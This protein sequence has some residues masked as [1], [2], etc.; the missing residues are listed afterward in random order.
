[1][2][3]TDIDASRDATRSAIVAMLT[4]RLHATRW[5]PR[6]ALVPQL[7]QPQGQLASWLA[8]QVPVTSVTTSL[9]LSRLVDVPLL[10]RAI[11]ATF[12][13]LTSSFFRLEEVTRCVRG[14][15]TRSS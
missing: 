3:R 12:D 1:M 5:M 13:L 7:R 8:R 4:T 15:D 6:L 14:C 9:E 10:A 11:L 2:S